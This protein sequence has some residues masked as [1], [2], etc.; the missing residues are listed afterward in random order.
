M[1]TARRWGAVLA[2]TSAL[3][4][5]AACGADNDAEAGESVY[6]LPLAEQFHA[7]TEATRKA[8]TAAFVSTLTYGTTTGDAVQRT[9]GSLDYGRG[10]SLAAVSLTVDRRFHRTAAQFVG[11]P[12]TTVEQ[13]LATDGDDVYVR[14]GTSPWLR[15]TPEAVSGLGETTRAVAAH[16]AGDVAPYSGTLADLVPR[17]IP[18]QEPE[19]QTDGSRLYRVTALAE[20]AA[21]ILPPGLQTAEGGDPVELTVRLDSEGRLTEVTADLGPVLVG[22]HEENFLTGSIRSLR[23]TYE[24]SAFGDPVRH[25]KP[26]KGVEDALK[27]LAP[28]GGLKAGQCAA[29]DTGL[30]SNGVVRPVDCAESH[31]MRVLAQTEVDRTFPG[32]RAEKNGNEYADEQCRRA[33]D[34]APAAWLRGAVRKDGFSYIGSSDTTVSVGAGK[35]ETSVTGA[36]TCYVVTS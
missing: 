12:G 5:T 14:D 32:D 13:T 21:E 23:A 19:R 28:V 24:L 17:T 34:K 1:E 9:E 4:G 3:V 30:G 8:G 11:E 33:Y 16:A 2:L 22:M 15:Y 6:G 29:T 18:R 26:G 31:D 7:A 36:Y 20:V 27:A 25:K 10:T 35:T